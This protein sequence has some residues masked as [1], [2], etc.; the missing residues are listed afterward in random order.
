MHKA[1]WKTWVQWHEVTGGQR[2]T[3]EEFR[4]LLKKYNRSSLLI[5]CA[6]V[7][8][9]FAYGP[10]AETTASDELT[11]L[12]TRILFTPDVASVITLKP[13]IRYQFKTGQRDWPKT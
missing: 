3:I 7:S 1:D 13:A 9:A 10:E 6:Q 8:V 11:K 2:G 12:W 5:M 4:E